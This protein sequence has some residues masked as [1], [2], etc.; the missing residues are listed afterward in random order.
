MSV[1][2]CYTF[3][4][5]AK[6]NGSMEVERVHNRATCLFGRRHFFLFFLSYTRSFGYRHSHLLRQPHIWDV[7][8]PTAAASRC[9][10][11]ETSRSEIE[12]GEGKEN[13]ALESKSIVVRINGQRVNNSAGVSLRIPPSL[14]NAPRTLTRLL[15]NLVISTWLFFCFYKKF[16]ESI[17]P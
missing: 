12:G 13:T 14:R 4:S 6:H 1:F 5:S 10:G 9:T 11:K 15:V 2:F 8:D 3:S 16:G 17:S 7:I